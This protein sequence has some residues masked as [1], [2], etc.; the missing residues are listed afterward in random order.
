MKD[1][2]K[3]TEK[4]HVGESVWDDDSLSA[5]TAV[6]VELTIEGCCSAAIWAS[7]LCTYVCIHV[8]F[9]SLYFILIVS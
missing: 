6:P 3:W 2:L 1:S 8:I 9:G 7:E 4:E 5:T